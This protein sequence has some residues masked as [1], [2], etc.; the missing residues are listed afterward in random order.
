MIYLIH[1]LK[2][3]IRWKLWHLEYSGERVIPTEMR[4]DTTTWAEHLARYIFTI[5]FAS[6]KRVLDIAC[7]TGYGSAL[8]SSV[9]SYVKGLDRDE[10]SIYWARKNNYFYCNTDLFVS[11]IESDKIIEKFDIIICFETLEHLNNPLAFLVKLKQN[12]R[13]NGQLIFSVPLNDPPNHFHKSRY[14]WTTIQNLALKS[15]GKKINWFS[16]IGI[17][18]TKNIN[19]NAKFSIGI[20]TKK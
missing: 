15:L 19:L 3:I 14:N 16:Q 2:N 6:N 17:N 4:R 7:G 8:L 11:D 9:A 10:K 12:L 1:N 18:I 20:W 5:K 13:D